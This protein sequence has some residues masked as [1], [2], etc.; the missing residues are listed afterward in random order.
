MP[1]SIA[2]LSPT[3][4]FHVPAEVFDG[5]LRSTGAY[6]PLLFEVA[7]VFIKWLLLLYMYRKRIFLR[8]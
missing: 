2:L 8:V 6:Q 4:S 3:H 7:D 1:S 5:V